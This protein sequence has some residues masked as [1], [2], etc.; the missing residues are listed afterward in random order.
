M[1]SPK[2]I[3][4]VIG[5]TG[6]QGSS[7]AH[8]FL[9]LSNWHVRCLSRDSSSSASQALSALGAEVVQADLSNSTSLTKAFSDA[10]AIFLNTDFWGAYIATKRAA[11]A[12]RRPAVGDSQIGYETEVLYGKNVA[13]AAAAVPSLERL[14]YSALPGMAKVSNGKYAKSHHHESKATVVEYIVEQEPELAKKTSFIYLGA[15]TTNALL[16]PKLNP[17]DGRYAFILPL[18]KDARLPIIDARNSTG[19][20]VRALIEDEDPGTKLLAYDSYL[21]MGEVATLWI[22]ASGMEADYVEVNADIMHKQFGVPTDLLEGPEALK[23][24]GYM[25]GLD[26]YIEPFQLKKRIQTKSFEDWLKERD[27]KEALEAINSAKPTM[28]SMEE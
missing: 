1:S 7:V 20:F 2:K 8:T 26:G 17:V 22:K 27:W 18:S 4:V 14:I 28:R 21:S 11:A 6:N 13:H 19:P 16:A 15:Y 3:I 23:E 10:N 5:A 24:Y 9:K 12:Q 25:G